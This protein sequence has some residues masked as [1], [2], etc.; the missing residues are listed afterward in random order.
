LIDLLIALASGAA[1]AYAHAKKE[2]LAALPGVAIAA[3]LVPPLSVVGFGLGSGHFQLVSG[4]FLL[5]LANLLAI[6]IASVITFYLLG[7]S[8][9]RKKEEQKQARKKLAISLVLFALIST[10]LGYFLFTSISDAQQKRQVETALQTF[11]KN[12]KDTQVLS[13]QTED[14]VGKLVITATLRGPSTLTDKA[15]E[16]LKNDLIDKLGQ[17]VQLKIIFIPAIRLHA[18]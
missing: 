2:A 13:V 16:I 5:Y 8:P 4:A 15:L 9:G 3:A 12:Y 14:T 6:V 10:L 11:L 18:R 7:F 17:E 1:G